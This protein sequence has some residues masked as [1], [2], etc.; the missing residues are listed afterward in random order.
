MS[1]T[2]VNNQNDSILVIGVKDARENS[3]IVMH[4]LYGI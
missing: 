4:G 2:Y 1:A 3:G